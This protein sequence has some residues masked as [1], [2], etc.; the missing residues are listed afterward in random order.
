[1][2]R[3]QSRVDRSALIRC[4]GAAA[5]VLLLGACGGGTSD[6]PKSNASA[7]PAASQPDTG[8]STPAV[9]KS[10]LHCAP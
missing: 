2:N 7:P 9:A 5:M 3:Y 6:G 4:C 10:T 1:M 8:A